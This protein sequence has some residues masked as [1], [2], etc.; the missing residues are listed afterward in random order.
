MR[1]SFLFDQKEHCAS[2]ITR[3]VYSGSGRGQRDAAASQHEVVIGRRG[4]HGTPQA[5]LHASQS[6]QPLLP[7]MPSRNGG[8]SRAKGRGAPWPGPCA[9][10]SQSAH[11]SRRAMHDGRVEVHR[12]RR[13]RCGLT[14][15]GKGRRSVRMSAP[16]RPASLLRCGWMD[17]SHR[18]GLRRRNAQAVSR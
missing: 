9:T 6:E 17:C 5:A 16:G 12:S 14:R 7:K 3:A 2:V 1:H 10:S 4:R 13:D 11:V 15:S 18:I 8:H